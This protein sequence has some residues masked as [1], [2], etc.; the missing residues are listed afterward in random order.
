MDGVLHSEPGA[1]RAEISEHV[2][3]IAK[4]NDVA[5]KHCI[6]RGHDIVGFYGINE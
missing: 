5:G 6:V 4:E 1:G 3:N 2:A